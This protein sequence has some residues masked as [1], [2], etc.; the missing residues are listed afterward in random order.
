M[1][2]ARLP[3]ETYRFLIGS[4]RSRIA[5]A[6]QSTIWTLGVALSGCATPPPIEPE[7]TARA[8]TCPSCVE[9]TR[10]IERLRQDLSAREAE[11]RDL[12]SSQRDQV[13]ELQE[14]TR[15]VARAKVKLRT[16]RKVRS[17]G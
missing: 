13:K 3:R 1:K 7:A 15:E 11:L 8:T 6:L 5:L 4:R 14:S 9:Q 2:A 10:E 12:R 17:S 16:S